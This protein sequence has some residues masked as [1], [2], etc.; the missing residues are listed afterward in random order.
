MEE[1]NSLKD[2]NIAILG[3]GLMGASIA[4]GLRGHCKKIL[5]SDIDSLVCQLAEAKEIVDSASTDLREILPQ[6]DILI[7]ATP[8]STAL[9]I[10]ATLPSIHN[11]SKLIVTDVTSTKVKIMR[12]LES[13]PSNFDV[14]GGHPICGKEKLGICNAEKEMLYDATY[15]LTPVERTST[16]TKSLLTQLVEVIGANSLWIDAVKH[17]Q[18]LAKTSHAPHLLAVALMHATETDLSKL[19]AGGFSSATRLSATPTSMMLSM[20]MTNAENTIAALEAVKAEIDEILTLMKADDEENL[21]LL[22][23]ASKAKREEMMRRA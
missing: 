9:E 16:R 23:D 15:T 8:V 18:M 22:L 12:A 17:D 3:L 7:L 19:K 13:L 21:T 4:M 10:I 20:V 6:A 14:I 5:G 11:G 2:Q 1:S